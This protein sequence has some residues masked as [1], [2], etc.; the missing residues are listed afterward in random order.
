R[1]RGL[2]EAITRAAGDPVGPTI[3]GVCAGYQ[4]LGHAIEDEYESGAGRV[5]AL[6][7][8][9]IVTAFSP[10][11]LTRPRT[12]SSLTSRVSGYEIHQGEPVWLPG[13]DATS[14]V[15]LDDGVG[16]GPEGCVS[17]DGR[18]A[19]T[20]LHGLFES[21]DFRAAWLDRVARRRSKS[22]VASGVSLSDRRESQ[23]DRLADAVEEFL[24]LDLLAALI[25][26]TVETP[27]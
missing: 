6:G 4:M 24:D 26:S 11:K 12:G 13:S 7:L 14:L 20:S 22:F 9:P 5:T 3:L 23:I 18:V 2:A 16:T 8:L 25:S 1:E 27:A 10:S 21:D 19:G 15:Q 17:A